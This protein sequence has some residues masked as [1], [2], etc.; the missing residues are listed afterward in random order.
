MKNEEPPKTIEV[1][2]SPLCE[3]TG[4]MIGKLR[5]WLDGTGVQIHI[6]PFD[7]CPQGLKSMFG[8]G[9]NCFIDVFYCGNRIDSVPLHQDKIYASLG[10]MQRLS[11]EPAEDQ[12]LSRSEGQ[13]IDGNTASSAIT[14]RELLI[15]ALRSGDISFLPISPDNYVDEMSMCL[16][17][18]PFGNPPKQFH[19]E[20]MTIKSR[21]FSD[22]W[23]REDIAGIYAKY[24]GN[25][26]GLLEVMPREI[27]KKYGY[28]TGTLGNDNA[29]LS[30]GCYEVGYGIPRID[31]I[32]LLMQHLEAIFPLF[33]RKQIEGVG[34]YDW[35]DGFNPYWVYKK[36]GFQETEKLSENVVIMSRSMTNVPNHQTPIRSAR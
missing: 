35:D 27:L 7:C 5:Q 12:T 26:I 36:Y 4:A 2:Y 34:I 20:C 15:N 9:E 1:V 31:M 3:S 22:V 16:C 30:I 21:V 32:D 18:Y 33:H 8:R 25:V 24:K 14:T 29:Y 10:I 11:D 28:M 6:F 17:N 19:R 23:D 13:L